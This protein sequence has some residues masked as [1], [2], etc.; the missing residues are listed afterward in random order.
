MKL[1]T[2]LCLLLTATML[3]AA[4]PDEPGADA[5]PVA[6]KITAVTVYADRARVTRTGTVNLPAGTA[7]LAFPKLP[8]WIDEGSVRLGIAPASAG[9][10]VDVQVLK[11]YL[12]RPDDAE[13]R[14]AQDAVQE[15]TDQMAAQEDERASL[16]AQARQVDA[17]RAFSLEKFPKDSAAREVKVEEYTGVVKFIGSSLLDIAK[18]KRE[19]EKKRRELQPELAARQKKLNDLRQRAQLEQRTVVVTVKGT[20]PQPATLTL[21]YMLPGATWAPVHELRA[22]N[23]AE[24]VAVASFGVVTQT[25]GEDWDGVALSLST[26][27]SAATIRIPELEKL[28][29][30]GSRPLPRLSGGDVDSFGLANRRYNDQIMLWNGANN[31]VAVQRDFERNYKTQAA[32]QDVNTGRFVTL[33]QQRGTTA[34]F[35]GLGAQLIRTD[36]RPVRVP[37][38]R[39]ELAAQPKIV[40]APEMS[41]NAVR[42]A[43]LSNSGR[44]PLLPGKV[45]L[46]VEGAFVGTTEV[47]FVAPGESFPMFLGVADQIKLSRALDKK[48]SELTWTGKRTRMQV[49]YVVTVENLAD[50]PVSLQLGDRVP[51][52]ETDEVRVLNTKL[53]PAVKPDIKG[54][55]KWDVKLAAKESKEFRLEYTLEYPAGLPVSATG[56]SSRLSDSQVAVPAL[57]GGKGGELRQQIQQ[58]EEQL[59]K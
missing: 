11:T 44:E 32:D 46:Y 53:T 38:G 18:A 15:I 45:L 1:L 22:A 29:V 7:R 55:V 28:L 57:G 43:E 33:Q 10:L 37:I 59:K 26:Q 52:S 16:D 36:G 27:N 13:L 2:S 58:L 41:L 20:A 42:T 56:S 30:G 34:H 24:K 47:E 8:G 19:L 25:T 3:L 49:S 50:Q 4:P 6:S 5:T 40:A 12:T 9:E 17:I 39:V 14:K 31:S 48:N 35:A 51:V 23:G 21:T 54:L